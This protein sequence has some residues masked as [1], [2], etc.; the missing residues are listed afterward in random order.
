MGR[1]RRGRTIDGV[2]LLAKRNGVSSN[3]ALQ[4]VRRLYNAAKA[5]HTGS[6]DPLASG[7]LPICMGQATKLSGFLLNTNK[8]YR[9]RVRLGSVT[10][11]GDAEGE[12]IETGLVPSLSASEI[13]E[14]LDKFTG[15]ISQIPPMFS[16]LK[17]NGVRL[18]KLARK[19]IEIEREARSVTIFGLEL[20]DYGKDYLDL[21]V[22]CSKG[23]YVRVLA[24]DIGRVLGCGGCVEY[25]RRT[26]VGDFSLS[27]AWDIDALKQLPGDRERLSCILPCDEAVRSWPAVEFTDELVCSMRQGQA[28][29]APKS[30][31]RGWV[32]LYAS[33]QKFFGIGEI[34][35]DQRIAPRKLL[36][37]GP[38]FPPGF[39]ARG[40]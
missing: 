22:R 15:E 9:V 4:E 31:V 7:L 36:S 39:E 14:V 35:P 29:F 10:T 18:Y 2:L 6:L 33:G 30:P 25:L 32:R 38:H 12:V 17:N 23:T 20:L 13:R 21:D 16:A 11:T 40:R 3:Y 34:L 26:E 19:G 27:R 24:E 37:L 5:G 1:Q 8:R 28:V